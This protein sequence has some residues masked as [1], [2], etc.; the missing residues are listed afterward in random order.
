M[1]PVAVNRE[2]YKGDRR[3][4]LHIELDITGSGIR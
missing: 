2:L 3:S 1:S 4:C